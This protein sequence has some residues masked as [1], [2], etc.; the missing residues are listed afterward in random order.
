MSSA[1]TGVLALTL[2]SSM[3]GTE[4]SILSLYSKMDKAFYRPCIVTLVGDGSLMRRARDHGIDAFHLAMRGP[5][6]ASIVFRIWEIVRA[7]D[8]SILHTYLYHTSILGRLLGWASMVPVV[9][10]SMRSTDDWRNSLHVAI[11]RFT[12]GFVT[13]Y[14]ANCEAV[15]RRLTKVERIAPAKIQVVRTGIEPLAAPDPVV[16]KAL[17][18]EWNILGNG[19]AIGTVANFRSAKG[20]FVLIEAAKRVLAQFP[21]AVF[22]WAGDG[23]LRRALQEKISREGLEKNFRLLGFVENA[24]VCHGAFDVFVLPSLWEGLPRVLLEAMSLGLPIV[25]TRVGGIPEILTDGVD[26]LLVGPNDP[27]ALADALLVVLR[28]KQ[29]RDTF[30]RNA[31]A[32]FARENSLAGYVRETQELYRTSLRGF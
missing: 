31:K 27:N 23:P 16:A 1:P 26:S 4:Q 29:T 20:H 2:N 5:L 3:G 12:Q 15:A 28:S 8:I 19:L 18:G 24:T 32:R 11:D 30:G 7:R 21:E 10:C 22:V 6:D 25:A 17:R 9:L 13:R 14:I